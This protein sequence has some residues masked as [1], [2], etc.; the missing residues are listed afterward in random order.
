VVSRA[1]FSSLRIPNFRRYFIGSVISTSGSWVQIVAQAWLVLK[2]TGSGTALG[3][4]TAAQFLPVLLF[5][6]S[7]GVIADRF[8]KR[9][10]LY[11][12]QTSLGVAALTLG[13]LVATDSVEMWMVYVI[14]WCTG[15]LTAVDLPTRHTFVVELVG[16][17]HLTNAVTMQSVVINVAR[18]VGPTL[19]ATMINTLGLAACFL[20]NGATFGLMIVSLVLMDERQL[21]PPTRTVRAP[22]Q[23]REGFAYVRRTREVFVL[24]VMMGVVGTLGFEMQVILPLIARFTFDGDAGLYSLMTAAMGSGA[25]LAATVV[26]TLGRQRPSMLGAIAIGYGFT[27]CVAAAA[28]NVVAVLLALVFVGAAS[29][30]FLAVGNATL[31]LVTEPTMRGRVMGLW[32]TAF[33]GTTPIGGPIVG[34]VGEHVSPR[35]GLGVGGIS[36]VAAGAVGYRTLLGLERARTNGLRR[37][38][39]LAVQPDDAAERS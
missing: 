14:S 33:L 38:V 27:C 39:G 5:A 10:A 25:L 11:I 20:F 36:S 9:K 24:L 30:I 31:Q 19:A 29:I 4:V 13:L 34:W 1:I 32:T 3:L 7:G 15:C 6:T 37:D 21:L 18:I 12:V 17:D 35:W 16:P 23:L 28:P 2:L 22:G 26:A 8:S